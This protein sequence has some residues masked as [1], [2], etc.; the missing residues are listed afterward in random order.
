MGIAGPPGPHEVSDRMT[1]AP[2]PAPGFDVFLSYNW[3]DHEAAQATREIAS[4]LKTLGLNPFL[5]SDSRC[6]KLGLSWLR[7]LEEALA[8]CAAVAVL[9]GPEGL[10]PWQ[11]REVDVALDRQSKDPKFPV[12][13]VLLPR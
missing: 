9:C 8:A 5:D 6:L 7:Q 4:Q 12:I 2:E 1:M 13:P 10:G 11:Q 3:N